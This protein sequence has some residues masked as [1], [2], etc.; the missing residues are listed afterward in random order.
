[1]LIYLLERKKSKIQLLKH[2]LK[3]ELRLLVESKDYINSRLEE[4][5]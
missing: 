2:T 1:M 4:V 5:K 3:N